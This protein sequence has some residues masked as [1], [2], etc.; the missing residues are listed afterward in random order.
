[1]T[2]VI[3]GVDAYYFNKLNWSTFLMALA[4][5]SVL[6]HLTIRHGL[7]GGLRVSVLIKYLVLS[8][9][10][11]GAFNSERYTLME[12]QLQSNLKFD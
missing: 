3:P 6:F 10:W 4:M 7:E 11:G 1:V 12:C 5:F 2:D 8:P 9:W